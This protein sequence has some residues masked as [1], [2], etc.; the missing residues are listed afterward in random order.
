[1]AG[2]IKKQK[3]RGQPFTEDCLLNWLMQLCM[4]LAYIHSKNV[5]HRDMKPQN[6]FLDKNQTAKIADF[7]IS[8]ALNSSQDLRQT[9]LG[10]PYYS[11]PEIF[12]HLEYG[13]EVDMWSLGCM[14]YELCMLEVSPSHS[15]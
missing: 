8:A 7:G 1:M 5:I 2:L 13:R 9:A 15:T 11:S 3:E 4:G 14:M 12:N 10:T 6:V